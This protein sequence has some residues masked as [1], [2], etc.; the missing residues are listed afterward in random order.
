MYLVE[1]NASATDTRTIDYVRTVK[2]LYADRPDIYRR[3]VEILSDCRAGSLT[4]T[5]G[6]VVALFKTRPALVLR[7]NEFLPTGCQ[8]VQVADNESG[9]KSQEPVTPKYAVEMNDA[10]GKTIRRVIDD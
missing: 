7:F 9:A 6:E 5:V 4:D 1:L 2:R 8:I 10:M 3:F